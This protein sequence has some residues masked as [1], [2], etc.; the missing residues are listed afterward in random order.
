MA[1]RT[2]PANCYRQPTESVALNDNGVTAFAVV[3]KG[4]FSTLETWA[5]SFDIGDELKDGNTAL[6]LYAQTWQLDRAPGDCGVLAVN[7][8]PKSQTTSGG[9]TA[10]KCLDDLWEVRTL[11]NDMSIFSYCGETDVEPSRAKIEAWMKE[12]DGVLAAAFKF[13]DSAK[14]EVALE[15]PSLDVAKKIALGREA[16]IRFYAAITRTRTYDY[17]PPCLQNLA[18]VDTP[19]TGTASRAPSNIS[20]V[21]SGHEWLKMQDDAIQQPYKTWKR[22]ESWWGIPT[23][24]ENPHPWDPNFYGANPWPIPYTGSSSST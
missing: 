23:S 1:Q 19:S 14:N 18:R 3:V 22:I 6:G 5:K 7:C 13:R 8:L 20:T 24:N 10:Q 21:I 16:V 11:R 17:P 4:D 9:S 2:I 15:S 12:P